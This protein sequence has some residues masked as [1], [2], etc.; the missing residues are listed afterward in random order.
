MSLDYWNIFGYGVEVREEMFDPEKVAKVLGPE[1]EDGEIDMA[2]LLE[3]LCWLP[4][5]ERAAL[6]WA[7][8]GDMYD[9]RVWYLYC[10]AV[11]PWEAR[12]E[13]WRNV[14]PE[15]VRETILGLL[16]PVLRDGFNLDGLEF[17]EISDVGC[18]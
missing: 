4:Q 15:S 6:S 14:T 7:S 1:W 17:D 11:L 3:A 10:P 12:K 8:T 16:K 5:A 13:P 18:G 2:D 9:N